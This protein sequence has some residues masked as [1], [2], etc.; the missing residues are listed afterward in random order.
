MRGAPHR[1]HRRWRWREAL[2]DERFEEVSDLIAAE[3]EARKR[4]APGVTTPDI[5]RI[6]EAA[7]AGGGAA[8]V[9]GAGGAGWW[10]SGLRPEPAGR[11]AAKA[12]RRT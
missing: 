3:W 4:L 2:L 8:K 6:A 5:D 1:R 10:R 7:R 9:C 12:S 11:D